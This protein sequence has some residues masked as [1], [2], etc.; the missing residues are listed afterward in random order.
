METRILDNNYDVLGSA[1]RWPDEVV[2]VSTSMRARIAAAVARP[3]AQQPAWPDDRRL[4]SVRQVLARMPALVTPAEIRRLRDRLAGV[5]NG[6]AFLLQGGDCAETF[7]GNTRAHV[8]GNLRTL[9]QM[10]VVLT[11]AAELPV[12]SVGRVAGQYAKPRSSPVDMLGLPAY[13]GDIVNSPE[14]TPS[15]RIPDPYRMLHAYANAGSAMETVRRTGVTG[16]AGLGRIHDLN[17]AF[18]HSS[19]T[20]RRY[21]GIAADIDRALRFMTAWGMDHWAPDRAEV[22]SSHEAL[23]LDYEVALLRPVATDRDSVYAGSG[24]FLWLGERTRELTGAHI[25]LAELIINPVGVKLG[26]TT[27]PQDAVRY[28]EVLDPDNEPGRLTF[29]T[30]MGHNRIRTVLPPIVEAVT[31]S[32]HRVVWQCDPMHG[33]TRESPTGYKTRRFDHILDEVRGFFQVHRTLGTHPGGV[34]LELTGDTVTECLGGPHDITDVDL[35]GYYETACDP[36]LNTQ[37]SVELAFLLAEIM[38]G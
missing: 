11:Y 8:E 10:A 35:A 33:N 20:G 27:T 26:P 9:L 25:A 17:H 6:E 2:D 14:L 1:S 37:Q 18:V 36:R 22:F 29:T 12:V 30:R 24:H 3:A 21:R 28:A 38:R 4:G 31:A 23:L 7:A 32:G 13:R 34:H 16:M 19:P 15:A 5:A